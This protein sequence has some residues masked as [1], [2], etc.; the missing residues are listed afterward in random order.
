MKQYIFTFFEYDKK[1]EISFQAKYTTKKV[2]PEAALKL[3]KSTVKEHK[4]FNKPFCY[5]I[6]QDGNLLGQKDLK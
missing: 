2:T 3:L 1:G 5:S 6:T 4:S